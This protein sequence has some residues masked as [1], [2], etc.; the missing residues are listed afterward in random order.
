MLIIKFHLNQISRNKGY[1]QNK[2]TGAQ[3]EKNY[4]VL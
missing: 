3:L 2:G 1:N 4:I